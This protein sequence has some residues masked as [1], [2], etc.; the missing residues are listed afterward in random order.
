MK[1]ESVTLYSNYDQLKLHATITIPDIELKGVIHVMHGLMENKELYTELSTVLASYG[2][3]VMI[4][5]QRGHGQSFDDERPYG[6]FA[7]KDGWIV[8]LKD[9]NRFAKYIRERYR[10]LPYFI[11]GCGV[12]SLIARS[13]LKRYEHEISGMVL[14]NSLPYTMNLN[15]VSKMLELVNINKDKQSASFYIHQFYNLAKRK[16]KSKDHLVWLSQDEQVIDL[17]QQTNT[18][19]QSFTIGLLKD[20]MFG[21]KDV[22]INDDWHPLKKQLPVLFLFGNDDVCVEYPKGVESSI[23]SLY[24]CG[25]ENIDSY[26]YPRRHLLFL[27]QEKEFV[28]S[29]LI[30]WLNEKVKK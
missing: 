26:D 2:Y 11:I 14:V 12:G 3:V 19:G 10:N 5:D 29:D 23:L 13:Y 22:Y 7:D 20:L 18:C 6:Y 16:C 15:I 9:N 4:C 27:G 8:N 28:Y 30:L 24:N 21:Y 17:Y 25:Y 1:R